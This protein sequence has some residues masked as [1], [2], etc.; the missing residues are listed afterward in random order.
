VREGWRAGG[1][2]KEDGAGP[3]GEGGWGIGDEED[4]GVDG[5]DEKEERKSC[6]G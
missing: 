1:H 3:C 2:H 5:N 6:H 4:G